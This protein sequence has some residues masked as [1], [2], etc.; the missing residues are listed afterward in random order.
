[1][2]K[3]QAIQSLPVGK[4]AVG[5][6]ERRVALASDYMRTLLSRCNLQEGAAFVYAPRT[7]AKEHIHNLGQGGI[8]EGKL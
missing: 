3:T 8:I 7:V 2:E 4:W 1:M 5:Y 6:I